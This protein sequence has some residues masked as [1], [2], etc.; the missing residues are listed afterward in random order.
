MPPAERWLTFERGY[1]TES[2]TIEE[3]KQIAKE[4]RGLVKRR[5]KTITFIRSASFVI[6]YD[7]ARGDRALSA[8]KIFESVRATRQQTTKSNL[9]VNR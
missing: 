1:Q 6:V 2:A 3:A 7:A 9:G 8:G 5:G 4:F